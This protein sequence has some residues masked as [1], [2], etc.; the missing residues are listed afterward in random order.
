MT[1]GSVAWFYSLTVCGVCVRAC[2][3]ACLCVCVCVLYCTYVRMCT[4][5]SLSV[6]L[7]VSLY[8]HMYVCTYSTWCVC[9][10]SKCIVSCIPHKLLWECVSDCLSSA[11][12]LMSVC[13]MQACPIELLPPSS[14]NLLRY[15]TLLR[16]FW[17][18]S[19]TSRW[20]E[21][22]RWCERFVLT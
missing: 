1:N 22:L 17:T 10:T 16:H 4:C 20:T 9:Y 19:W 15:I 7:S 3:H 12:V 14:S 13:C 8:V 11:S 18:K 21:V 2:V 6:S 5:V